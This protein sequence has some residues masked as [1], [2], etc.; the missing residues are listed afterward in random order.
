MRKSTTNTNVEID[1]SNPAAM[2]AL[3]AQ[4]E[5]LV[6][7]LTKQ[8][9]DSVK[10]SWDDIKSMAY[11][12][13]AIAFKTYDPQRSK[14]TF[15]QFAGFAIRNNIL[16]GLNNELRTVKLSAY[17]QKKAVES[18]EA[19]FNS[20]SLDLATSANQASNENLHISGIKTKDWCGVL[21]TSDKWSDGDIF[22][23]LYSKLEDNFPARD[24]EIFYMTFG[25]NGHDE[26]KGK[27]IADYFG[28]SRSL[29]S[30]KVKSVI[31]F[32]QRDEELVEILSNLLK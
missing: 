6:N 9:V 16:T 25:L 8:F 13:L 24:C 31:K 32:I 7:K 27:D 26:I 11:E 1:F 17:A 3:A 23:T 14:M 15:T 30:V 12:G 21:S 20:V 22:E 18:G 4:Y 19:I 29:V 10:T 2:N 28:I 5:P